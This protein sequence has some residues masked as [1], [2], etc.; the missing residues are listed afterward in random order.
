MLV[1]LLEAW[2]RRAGV[3]PATAWSW[4]DRRQAPPPEVRAAI[5][6]AFYPRVRP[7]DF[8]GGLTSPPDLATVATTMQPAAAPDTRKTRVSRARLRK[9][10]RKHPFVEALVSLGLTVTE[11]ARELDYPRSTVQSWYDGEKGNARPIP[12]KAAEAIRARLGVP[13]S[14]WPRKVD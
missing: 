2:A 7:D 14:A 11:I 9:A 10:N 4:I 13:L 1:A 8:L 12:R 6:D 5:V 3:D